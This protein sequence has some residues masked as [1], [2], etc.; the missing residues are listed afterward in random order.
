[1]NE[2]NNELLAALDAAA[3]INVGD[4]VKGEVLAFDDQRQA[5]VGIQGTG[6]EGVI[7]GREYSNNPD[8]DIT[9]E[10][11]IGDVL[12][13]VVTRKIGSDKEGGSY[14]LLRSVLKYVRL[15][16]ILKKTTSLVIS[17][18]YLLSKLS[19]VAW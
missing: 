15:G 1:M 19:V 14:L 7:P 3:E 16:K 4:I 2:E 6:V 10:L 9:A 5:I 17:L 18:K 13:L 8:A 12:D 11:K